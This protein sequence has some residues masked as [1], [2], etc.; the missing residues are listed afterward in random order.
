L[1]DNRSLRNTRHIRHAL[2]HQRAKLLAL[3]PRGRKV[4]DAIR[5]RQVVRANALG[6]EIG[7]R[8]LREANLALARVLEALRA[9]APGD[10]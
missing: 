4:L 6:G 5:V 7:E 3:T 10:A 9:R 2:A 8:D 1:N